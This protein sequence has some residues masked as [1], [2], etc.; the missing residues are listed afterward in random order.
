M[1]MVTNIAGCGQSDERKLEAAEKSV[2]SW[3]ATV[4]LVA[5]SAGEGKAPMYYATLVAQAAREELEQQ[6]KELDQVPRGVARQEEVCAEL[7]RVQE[8]AQAMEDATDGGRGS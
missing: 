8:K 6:R 7:K 2:R 3:R 5:A 4:E 1:V